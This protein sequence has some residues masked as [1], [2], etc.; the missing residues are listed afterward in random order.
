MCEINTEVYHVD[1]KL[2]YIWSYGQYTIES[3]Q[4]IYHTIGIDMHDEHNVKC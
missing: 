3:K 1:S 2:C 4:C